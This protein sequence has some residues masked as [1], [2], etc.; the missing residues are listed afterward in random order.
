MMEAAE[1]IK[2][3][4]TADICV[5]ERR[6]LVVAIEQVCQERDKYLHIIQTD[7]NVQIEEAN[8][9]LEAAGFEDWETIAEG[10]GRL[11]KERDAARADVRRL[12][13]GLTEARQIV[14][15]E[16]QCHHPND[17]E[18]AD[19]ECGDIDDCLFHAFL[20]TIDAAMKESTK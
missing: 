10:I 3:I 1:I 19:G 7:L 8:A 17:Y 20:Q 12:R 15:S 9:A 11:A 18:D 16:M 13:K 6:L 5:E 4:S 2:L 14:T